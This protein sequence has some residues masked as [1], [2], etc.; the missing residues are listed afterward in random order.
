MGAAAGKARGSAEGKPADGRP[1]VR[2]AWE[3]FG[4]GT[5]YAWLLALVLGSAFY[6][7][8]GSEAWAWSARVAVALGMAAAYVALYAFRA[9]L[10]HGL[11][12][13]AGSVGAGVAAVAGTALLAFPLEG[14]GVAVALALAAVLCGASSALLM[15]GGNRAWA[16]LRPESVMLHVTLS[17]LAAVVLNYL[18]LVLPAGL[19]CAVVCLL[20]FAGSLILARTRVEGRPRPVEPREADKPQAKGLAVRMVAH[21]AAFSLVMGCTVAVMTSGVLEAALLRWNVLAM[22]GAFVLAVAAA[23]VA[24][25]GEPARILTLLSRAGMPL[26]EA[27]LVLLC[28]VAPGWYGPAA[29]P[30]MAGFLAADLFTWFLNSE[31]VARS[32][33]TSLEV[34]ARSAGVQWLAFAAGLGAGHAAVGTGGACLPWAYAACALVLVVEQALA[35]TPIH[36]ARL[37]ADRHDPLGDEGL[38]A[39]CASLAAEHGLTAREL[40]VLELLAH[41]RSVP[42]VQEALGISQGTAKTHA[43]NIYRKLGV[44]SR[45]ELLDAV[46][47]HAGRQ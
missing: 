24:L 26:M 3:I 15:V 1:R 47:S 35:L 41:G 9:H 45:Q 43:H 16:R 18:L 36:A 13:P 12:S 2:R 30:L 23:C 10:P 46:D 27:G 38:H 11:F 31:L 37:V 39:V 28:V 32:G 7:L 42:Y 25:L 44:Q 17:A 20:P 14:A 29:A 40:E 22:A 4:F 33:K 19:T 6:R 5:Q 8:G 34:L 21:V